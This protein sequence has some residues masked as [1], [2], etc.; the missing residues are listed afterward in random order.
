MLSGVEFGG[1][2]DECRCHMSRIWAS[3]AAG[4]EAGVIAAGMLRNTT[5]TLGNNT[6]TM[7]YKVN[8]Y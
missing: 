3:G 8:T 1:N 7:P 4:V 5:N 6:T 2:V